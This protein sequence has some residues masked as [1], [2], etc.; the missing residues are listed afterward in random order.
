MFETQALRRAVTGVIGLV[1]VLLVIV[2]VSG[3]RLVVGYLDGSSL[4]AGLLGS[5]S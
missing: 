4:R 3:D 2:T 1:G 5:R